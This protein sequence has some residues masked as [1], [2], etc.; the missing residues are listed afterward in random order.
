MYTTVYSTKPN[1][2]EHYEKQSKSKYSRRCIDGSITG[3]NKCVGYCQY[4][5]HSGFLT[6][7]Q[8]A[9]HNCIGK[10]CFYYIPKP[11][12]EEKKYE[13]ITDLSPTLLIKARKAIEENEGVRIIRVENTE[14]KQYCAYYITITNDCDF[15]SY[16]TQIQNEFNV[17]IKF[18]KLDYDLDKCIAL[19][20]A[21]LGEAI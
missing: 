10:G 2:Y 6:R 3:C 18:V 4:N 16:S 12:Y 1:R 7:E 13:R 11:K 9:E 15:E 17:N 8:R 19:L 21:D 20:Y 14:F 5:G